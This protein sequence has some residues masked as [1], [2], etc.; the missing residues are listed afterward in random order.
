MIPYILHVAIL[1]AGCYLF[2]QT[3]LK[4]ETFFG[5]NRLILVICV[6]LSFL[7]P[8]YEMPQE[9]SLR[10]AK[11]DVENVDE[12]V[13]SLLIDDINFLKED[14]SNIEFEANNQPTKTTSPITQT[15]Q[16]NIEKRS[17]LLSTLSFGDWIWYIYLIGLGIF[18][19][20]FLI[21]ITVLIT[22]ILK[23]P[24][25][26]DG[27]FRI[28]EVSKD[29]PP[30]SFWNNIFINPTKYDWETYNQILEHEK[31]HIEGRH[32]FDIL[33][34]EFVIILQWF[35]PFAW[36]YRKT[37]ES[38]LEYLTDQQMLLKGANKEF[39]QINLLK[40]SA[41]EFPLNITTN[42]N[43]SF[44]KKRIIMMEMKKSSARS[45][46]K[47][48]FL[49]PLLG[50]SLISLN[51]V[52]S[53]QVTSIETTE[54]ENYGI[55]T[56]GAFTAMVKKNLV[57]LTFKM[58]DEKQSY[59]W[60]FN[61]CFVDNEFSELPKTT[62][63]FNITR[64]A[65]TLNLNGK[66]A[67]KKGD[68]TFKFTMND[69]FKSYLSTT[70]NEDAIRNST[71]FS[72]FL[73]DIDK[74]YIAFLQSAGFKDLE[75]ADLKDLGIHE[76]KLADLKKM[77]TDLDELGYDNPN[78]QEVAQ[79]FVHDVT[80]DYIQNLGKEVYEDLSLKEVVAAKIHDVDPNYIKEFKEAGYD[81]KYQNIV[82][83]AVHEVDLKYIESLKNAG[84]DNLTEE[85]IVQA[86]IHEV[87]PTYLKQFED[88]KY[89]DLK[90]EQIIQFAIHEV[91]MDYIDELKNAGLN[92]L[93]HNQ[94]VQAAIHEIDPTYLKQFKNSKYADLKFDEIVQF[95]IHEVDMD[96]V[97]D[98]NR[99][100]LTDLTHN[101]IVQ[102][103]IHEV[104]PEYLK[105]FRSDRFKDMT[106][107]QIIQFAIH[108]VDI[109]YIDALEKAGLKDLTHQQLTQA[110][111]HDISPKYLS[112]FKNSKYSDM[113][114][115][116]IVQ[117]A[118]HDVDVKY[119]EK[120]K[121]AGYGN[122]SNQE[123][124]QFAIHDIDTDLIKESK[125][126][127]FGNIK[128][129][130]LIQL[131]IHNVDVDFVNDLRELGYTNLTIMETVQSR[132]HNVDGGFISDLN[133]L[134]FQNIPIS[135]LIDLKIH[136]V[137]AD[138]IKEMHS[139]GKT[140]LSLD[141]YKALKM[142]GFENE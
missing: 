117:F 52:K 138:F 38:N 50:L 55:P 29:K 4:N 104:N 3:L 2:Y 5:I 142:K 128:T 92:D 98:L 108:D 21:Q 101:Q 124:I 30:Y 28:I 26:R 53:N 37:I 112:Q 88:S 120:L 71:M 68:G 45:A 59:S 75:F 80:P 90:F 110:A 107:S 8:L 87:N 64:T 58:K 129:Q 114:F 94:L 17:S 35:N 42:Y 81:T 57:C 22:S 102:A 12:T 78:I 106:F 27:K 61:S 96:Y 103:A 39:Y 126:L 77:K 105:Q 40:I 134:G 62:K 133:D 67:S 7:L 10:Q 116:Q 32:T 85:Q 74:E 54:A 136:Q 82:N 70:F 118:I 84:L 131:A 51:T 109:Q 56:E 122:L 18:A 125:S 135:Q 34:A 97:E 47:Y 141:E 48:L 14:K 19:L 86:A 13:P 15:N 49:L 73:A 16:S 66:F 93:T 33:L 36:W 132:I 43:Q 23:Y 121:S 139:K 9:W 95:A 100:G 69:E 44:L 111:I 113:P 115:N 72:L 20:N 76:V 24:S 130:D 65:G 79:L 60:N 25:I 137:D 46:W 123:I 127:G 83:F 6:M 91:D 11:D 140:G 99:A 89:K 31:V 119:I 41:P 63:D 1:L